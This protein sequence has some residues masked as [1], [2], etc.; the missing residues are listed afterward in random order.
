MVVLLFN[1]VGF[2]QA[3]LYTD[4]LEVK[5]YSNR[6]MLDGKNGVLFILPSDSSKKYAV[7]RW[8][9]G[10]TAIGEMK[11]GVEVGSWYVYDGRNRLREFLTFGPLPECLVYRRRMSKGGRTLSEFKT[12]T[13]CF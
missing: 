11:V 8:K 4:T 13:P 9:S 10:Y 2:A 5:N 1:C 12:T 6:F 7:V 3:N